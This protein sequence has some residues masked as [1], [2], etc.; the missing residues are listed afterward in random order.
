MFNYFLNAKL[1]LKTPSKKRAL[2]PES[3]ASWRGL[4][5]ITLCLVLINNLVTTLELK[6]AAALLSAGLGGILSISLLANQP[7]LAAKTFFINILPGLRKGIF[8]YLAFFLPFMLVTSFNQILLNVFDL[9]VEP[10]ITVVWIL[11]EQ[12]LLARVGLILAIVILAPLCEELLFRGIILPL[13]AQLV[14]RTLAIVATSL[15]FA[16]IHFHIASFLPLFALAIFI[17][18]AYIYT[19]NIWTP[20]AM[21]ACFNLISILFILTFN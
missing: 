11:A 12:S 2:F 7:L 10:Q 20:I 16:L 15:L 6:P 9:P 18:I 14:N 1:G 3:Y 8:F 4:L 17:S 21:H 5:F 13:M 19:R